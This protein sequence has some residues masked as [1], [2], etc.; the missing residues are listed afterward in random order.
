MSEVFVFK[1]MIDS[2][3]RRARELHHDNELQSHLVRY[4]CIL[5][6]GYLEIAIRSTYA[7]YAQR[8][9]PQRIAH[10][11]HRSVVR[12]QNPNME[13]IL[14]ITG[15]FSKEWRKQLQ[16]ATEGELKDAVDSIV[17]NRNNIAHGG[18]VGLSYHQMKDYYNRAS[19]VVSIIEQMCDE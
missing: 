5:T 10:F 3:L 18:G 7:R 13:R 14:D 11:V 15:R 6:S 16:V 1:A 17:A 2:L 9:A 12:F 4:I 8:A 19:R